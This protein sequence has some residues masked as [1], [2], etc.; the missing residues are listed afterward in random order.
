[1]LGVYGIDWPTDNGALWSGLSVGGLITTLLL[2]GPGLS[3]KAVLRGKFISLKAHI[4]KEERCKN[5][6]A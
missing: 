6:K 3:S 1:M 2:A 5:K 4:R